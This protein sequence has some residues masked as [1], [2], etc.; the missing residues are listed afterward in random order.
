MKGILRPS[1]VDRIHWGGTDDSVVQ[2]SV[3]LLGGK[4]RSRHQW[5]RIGLGSNDEGA[6]PPLAPPPLLVP[7]TRPALTVESL[8]NYPFHRWPD[9]SGGS[10]PGG[11]SIRFHDDDVNDRLDD[12]D[13]QGNDVG[14]LYQ[15]Q[16]AVPPVIIGQRS[17]L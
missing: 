9:T 3:A 11:Y 17:G 8:L 12:D 6:W 15:D 16:Q 2:C 1:I 5:S 14:D 4:N 10:T 7:G 13:I